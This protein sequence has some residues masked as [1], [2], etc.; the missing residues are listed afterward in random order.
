IFGLDMES[1]VGKNVYDVYPPE[2]A[3][4]YEADSCEVIMTGE[5]IYFE[6][7]FIDPDGITQYLEKVETPIFD[8][9]GVVIGVC[10]I[11]HDITDSKRLEMELRHESTHDTLTGLYNRAFFDAE[12]ERLSRSRMFPLSIVMADLNGLKAVNDSLG[13]DAGDELLRL[14]ARI[15]LQAFRSED[16]VARIGGDE[17]AVLLP[18]TRKTI[19]EIAVSRLTRCPEI[20]NGLVSIAF[21][22]ATAED[23][24]QLAIALKYS[25]ERMYLDKS[26]KKQ[27][28]E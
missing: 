27:E 23:K 5:R 6:E 14:T 12:L 16:I 17:F 7:S 4:K 13:H 24:D 8:D 10:G 1:L 9:R 15:F 3:K 25:D 21:G 28:K 26:D 18:T 2:R 19:A 22:I 20:V 11:G